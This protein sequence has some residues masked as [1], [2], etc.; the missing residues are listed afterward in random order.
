MLTNNRFFQLGLSLVELMVGSAAGLIVLTAVVTTYVAISRSSI[1]ILSEAKL[2]AELRT[3]MD[4]MVRDIRRA[5]SWTAAF[6]ERE[7]E[8][9]PFTQR[10]GPLFTDI[11]ILDGGKAIEF[12]FNGSFMGVDNEDQYDYREYVFGYRVDDNA[13][14]VLQCV[15][16]PPTPSACNSGDLVGDDWEKL[17]DDRTVLIDSLSFTTKGSSCHNLRTATSWVITSDSTTPACDTSTSGYAASAG[18]RLLEKRLINV[19]LQ[20]KLKDR[21]EFAMV[22][23]Q[24]ILV[25]NDRALTAP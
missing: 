3:A 4:M 7:D 14:K 8:P 9:N 15:I 23:K 2:H 21:P 22:L 25:A 18:D 6:L 13:I 10:A 1:D 11:N 17:T 20:G 16:N 24:G 12:T 19:R 5:G